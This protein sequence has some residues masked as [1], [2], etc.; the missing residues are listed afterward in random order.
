[1]SKILTLMTCL[2][3]SSTLVS[4]QKDTLTGS[5]GDVIVTTATRSNL[6]QSQTGKIVTVIDRQ[7]IQNNVGRSLS[8]LLNN[9]AG[10]FI[11]GANNTLGTNQD[12]YFRG[13]GTGNMLVVIDGIPVFD[14]SQI[15]NSFD[16]NSI[17][18]QEIDHIEILKGGQSTL[19]GSDA[20]AGVIQLF[21]KKESKKTLVGNAGISYGSYQTQRMNAGISGTI[22]RLGYHVQYSRTTSHGISAAYD[23]LHSGSF[24]KDGFTQNSLQAS[25]RYQL[26]PALTA[27]A[28]GNFSS[29]HTDYDAG[30][31]T[32][33]K[34]YTAQNKN[35]LGGFTLQYQGKAVVWNFL[36]SYQQANRNFTNDSIDI[37]SI[38]SKYATGRYTGN[39][40]TLETFGNTRLSKNFSLVSGLEY[41]K[42]NSD[43]FYFSTG[44]FGA[45]QSA[46]S[47]DS[48]VI[49]QLS[50][51]G[52]LLFTDQR[53]FNMELG[54]RYNHH[55]IYGNKGT[56]TFN[57]S[58]LLSAHT[59][60]FLNISSAYKIP[61]LYQLYS[62]YG[63]KQLK[64]ESS[65]TYEL[66]IQQGS[67]N[68]PF[69]LRL[70]AFKRDASNLIL[71][72]TD[73]V[74]YASK[75]MNGD[76]QNDYGFELESNL[77]IS[78]TASW[79]TNFSYVDGKGTVSG[80]KVSNLYRRPV[81]TIS[82]GITLHPFNGFTLITS[83]RIVGS[84]LKGQYDIG[85]DK[86]PA[87]YTVDQF[88]AYQL[89][90]NIR[91]FLDLHNL[92]NQEYFDIVGYTSKRFNMMAGV[93]IQL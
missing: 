9:Q 77:A 90:K 88:A 67:F 50:A 89:Q 79:N 70:A 87:Y 20:V 6:K 39:T 59:K 78:K 36:A 1:M 35:N 71:F 69:Y 29:Y 28:F 30:A 45:Y 84:R 85:P 5:S 62:D 80:K 17:P 42:Q 66:G 19:W 76:R 18:L 22:A 7:T 65:V 10:F 93:D 53:K 61:S 86:Q 33:D 60:L 24:D 43:Q 55:S 15:N 68:D 13:A 91:F 51:Y 34:D 72:Y 8:E 57:P 56:F 46:L 92:T 4:A 11:N 54:G 83:A 16:F 64:P 25:L 38:Y 41:L 47:K 23:S 21:L 52:S 14:P 81:V 82:T 74:T 49:S 31:F 75:Y 40:T 27:S 63:N 32:D 48:A 12:I 3:T 37:S 2:I 58:Y 26:S 44:S 73:P